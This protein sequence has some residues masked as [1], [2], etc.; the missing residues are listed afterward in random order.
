MG[1]VFSGMC[2]QAA[3]GVEAIWG[4]IVI[5]VASKYKYNEPNLSLQ[6]ALIVFPCSFAVGSLAMQLGSV[7]MDNGVNPR[8]HIVIGAI[9]YAGGT[10]VSQFAQSFSM[11]I[12]WYSVVAGIGFGLNYNLPLKVAWSYF[13]RHQTLVSGIILSC[14]SINAIIACT[15]STHIVNPDN[16]PPEVKVH[17]G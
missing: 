3:L 8:V 17:I 5:Y 14:Y 1:A 2:I 6:F 11:F 16:S 9:L 4:N 10:Y 7:M 13:P 15:I 12:L